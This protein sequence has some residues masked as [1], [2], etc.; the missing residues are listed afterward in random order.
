MILASNLASC[1][2]PEILSFFI[3]IPLAYLISKTY[4][5]IKRSM[6]PISFCHFRGM[7]MKYSR[8]GNYIL[9]VLVC[10]VLVVVSAAIF[11]GGAKKSEVPQNTSLAGSENPAVTS[12]ALTAA[13]TAPPKTSA[14]AATPLPNNGKPDV[15]EMKKADDDFFSDSVF[16]GN[17]LVDGLYLYGGVS[18]CD[19]L[20][21]TGLSIYNIAAQ[22]LSDKHGGTCTVMSALG[23]KQYGKVYILLGINEIGSSIDSFSKSYG[24]IL[25][26]IRALQ[27]SADIY[28]MSL[29]PVS[30]Y[31]SAHSPYFTRDNVK[32]FNKALYKLCADGGYW[33]LDDY[34]P[35]ADKDGYL[36]SS[37]TADGVHF[38]TSY[39]PVWMDVIRTHYVART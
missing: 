35:L 34:T 25:S 12:P 22:K 30:A 8:S 1:G 33:Y 9:V 26:K 36:P 6:G 11:G 3:Q 27:P 2:P 14:P 4:N 19:W 20:S 7:K 38:V 23:A 32:A 39:Y 31:K 24:E 17:S 15:P 13:A 18:T 21:G 16:I 28:V 5:Q 10:I 29:T 37:A